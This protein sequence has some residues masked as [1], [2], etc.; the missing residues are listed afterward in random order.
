MHEVLCSMLTIHPTKEMLS[1]LSELHS[2]TP[3][4]GALRM[5]RLQ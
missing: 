3:R 5:N 2:M 1:A 4:W